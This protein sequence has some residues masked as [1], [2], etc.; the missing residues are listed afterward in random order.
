MEVGDRWL[1]QDTI[2]RPP[3]F[4]YYQQDILAQKG[5]EQGWDWVVTYPNDVI[6]VA[7]GNFMNLVTTL[8]MY[9]A[10]TKELGEDLVWPGSPDFYTKFTTFTY[11]RLHAKF[12]LWAALEK[13]PKVSNQAFN[14]TNGDIESWHNMWP[15]LAQ[16]FGLSIPARMF[17]A[18]EEQGKMDEEHGSVMKLME[19]T[20][21]AD[22]AEA[23][24]LKDTKY[25]KQSRVEQKYDLIKW[26]QRKEVKD[27]WDNLV[28]RHGL[29]HDAFEKATWGFLG[30][31]IG[32]NYDI[33][34]SMNKARKAGWLGFQDTYDS[35]SQCLDE[36]VDEKVLPAFQ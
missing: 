12:N 36:L 1:T 25:I 22:S 8:G 7:K 29:D 3:N 32:R 14:V 4:Y 9:C 33:V 31:V 27:A 10:I 18:D 26:S 11:S 24:G 21:L 5:H 2:D 6:G 20:P 30:F 23:R 19:R 16:K 35:L 15:K 34:I 28:E 17:S 13:S